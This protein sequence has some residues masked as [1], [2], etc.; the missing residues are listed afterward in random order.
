MAPELSAG[1]QYAAEPVDVFALGVVLFM[2]LTAQ[3]PFREAGDTHYK[4]F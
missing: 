1:E 4:R 2:M 3:E